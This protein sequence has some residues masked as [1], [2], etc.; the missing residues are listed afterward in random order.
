[1]RSSLSQQPSHCNQ[2][3][4]ERH[5]R[6]SCYFKAAPLLSA[7]CFAHRPGGGAE[8]E[9][10]KPPLAARADGDTF[11][12]PDWNTTINYSAECIKVGRMGPARPLIKPPHSI[13]V[14]QLNFRVCVWFLS[15]S[16]SSFRLC[17]RNRTWIQQCRENKW[18]YICNYSNRRINANAEFLKMSQFK[19][20]I[21]CQK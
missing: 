2:S 10:R 4:S 9:A 16:T 15:T 11:T 19:W 3:F 17:R 12:T 18:V 8:G 20:N 7:I 6:L 5:Y 1:M 13:T 14:T 21:L